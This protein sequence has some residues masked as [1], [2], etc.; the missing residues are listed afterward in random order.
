MLLTIGEET[1]V[2]AVA[3]V[4]NVERLL[5]IVDDDAVDDD[6]EVGG[7]IEECLTLWFACRQA[8][9]REMPRVVE[10]TAATGGVPILDSKAE[11]GM[12]E[13]LLPGAMLEYPDK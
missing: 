12:L 4:C 13:K 1:L 7:D 9:V 8:A 6:D 11:E 5:A 3:D 2:P 10:L